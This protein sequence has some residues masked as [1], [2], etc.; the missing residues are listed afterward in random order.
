MRIRIISTPPGEAPERIRAAWVGLEL[1]AARTTTSVSTIGVL[2]RP[3]TRTGLFFA[4]LFGRTQRE[5]GYTVR[6]SSAIE[7]LATRS[8]EAA[9][10]WCE[11]SPHAIAPGEYFLFAAEACEEVYDAT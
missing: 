8:P 3:K 5:V 7:M 1:P 2:S 9:A 10:W 11:N 4:W 6:A